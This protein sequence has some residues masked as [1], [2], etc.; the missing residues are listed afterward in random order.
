M[1]VSGAAVDEEDLRLGAARATAP[2]RFQEK[3]IDG[4]VVVFDGAH[5]ADSAQVLRESLDE[6]Y[7]GKSVVL[8]TNML[9]GHE[10]GDFYEPLRARSAHVVPIDFHRSR[11]VG[12]TARELRE[13][14]TDVSEHATALEG[15]KAALGEAG[16]QEVVVVTGSFY[17]VGDLL[18]TL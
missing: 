12:Q 4:R 13:W 1:D 10:V 16:E 11:P 7:P 9:Q 17:L 18:R 15:L 8:V 6:F 2:G 3:I 5:N 14:I